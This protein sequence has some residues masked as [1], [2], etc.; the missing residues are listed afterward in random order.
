MMALARTTV[1]LGVHSPLREQSFISESGELCA[2]LDVGANGEFGVYGSAA[3]LRRLGAALLAAADAADE[4]AEANERA[5]PGA[6]EA[7]E[8]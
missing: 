3:A 7:S 4:L 8:R 1:R 6:N 5:D 2:W